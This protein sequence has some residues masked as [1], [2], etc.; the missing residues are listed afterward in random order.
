MQDRSPAGSG[1]GGR[2]RSVRR[3]RSIPTSNSNSLSEVRSLFSILSVDRERDSSTGPLHLLLLPSP[4]LEG[5]TC[6]HQEHATVIRVGFL[7]C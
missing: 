3:R 7:N 5:E 1:D 4:K 2:R 6:L